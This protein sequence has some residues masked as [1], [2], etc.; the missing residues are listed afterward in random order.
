MA[1]KLTSPS[2]QTVTP[3]GTPAKR[4]KRVAIIVAAGLLIFAAPAVAQFGQ[5]GGEAGRPARRENLQPPTLTLKTD[6]GG[7]WGVV[8][9]VLLMVATAAAAITPVKRGHQD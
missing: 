7:T 8:A 3:Q 1:M 6:E 9:S 4:S 5:P 2:L